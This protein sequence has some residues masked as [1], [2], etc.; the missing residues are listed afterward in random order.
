MKDDFDF[1]TNLLLTGRLY[2][3]NLKVKMSYCKYTRRYNPSSILENIMNMDFDIFTIKN[4]LIFLLSYM[5]ILFVLLCIVGIKGK[6]ITLNIIT[7]QFLKAN[8]FIQIYVVI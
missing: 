8:Q 4:W 5:V 1:S 7:Y 2:C 6:L 3:Q